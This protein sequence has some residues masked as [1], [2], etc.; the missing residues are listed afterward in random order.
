MNWGARFLPFLQ[1][2]DSL[3]ALTSCVRLIVISILICSGMP[4]KAQG[5]SITNYQLVRQQTIQGTPN[6]TYRADLVNTGTAPPAV[7]ATVTSLNPS[8]FQVSAGQN[9]LQFA[10]VPANSQVT[11]S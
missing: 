3:S 4:G 1:Q 8:S 6:A 11:S 7:T 2:D 9:M 5:L 10:P